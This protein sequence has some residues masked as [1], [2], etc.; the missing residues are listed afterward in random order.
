MDDLADRLKAVDLFAGLEPAD[1][2][3]IASAAAVLELPAG[4]TLVRQGEDAESTFVLLDGRLAAVFEDDSQNERALPDMAPGSLV[5]EV[6][7]FAGGKRTATVR[8]KETSTLAVLSAQAF[9]HL[10][11]ANPAVASRVSEVVS[12]RLRQ[13]QLV[14]HLTNLFPDIEPDALRELGRVVEWISLPTGQILFRQGDVGDAAYLIISGRV[15]VALTDNAEG[16]ER[17]VGEIPSGEMV[18]EQAIL[19]DTKRSATIYAGRDTE[20]ARIPRAV[21]SAFVESHPEIMLRM[22]RT[23][24]ERSR[25]AIRRPRRHAEQRLSITVVALDPDATE[26]E[27]AQPLVEELT[28]FG[29]TIALSSEGIDSALYKPGI[30]ESSPGDPAHI[31]LLQW[32][33]DVERSHRFVIYRTDGRHPRWTERAIRQSDHVIFFAR[34]SG[35]PGLRDVESRTR[36]LRDGRPQRSSLVLRHARDVER[37]IG[38]AR[39]LALRDVESVHHVRAGDAASFARLARI[40]AG[41]AV[42]VVFG[43]GG[44]RGFAHLGVLRA[45][46]ELGVPVDIIGGASIGAAVSAPTAQGMR[47]DD[48]V[49]T[50]TH[51]FRSLL[52]YT[53]PLASL[54]SGRRITDALQRFGGT[55]DLEDLW[56]SYYCV[57]TNITT[58]RTVVHRRGNLARAV[59]ASIAIPGVLPPVPAGDDLLVDGGVL[60]NLPIDVMREINP[61]GPVIAVHVVSRK[62]PHA[63]A[64]FGLSLSGWRVAIGRLMPR[65]RRVDVPSLVT[66]ILRSMVVGAESAVDGML[67]DGLPDLYL[68]INASAVGLLAFETVGKVEKI[69]YEAAIEPLRTWIEGGGLEPA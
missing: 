30:S 12:R 52:D 36:P 69:G 38:T 9:A 41:R 25:A 48:A 47:I 37:P 45:L 14:T 63:K 17:V 49:A 67:N 50:V 58:S 40:L 23:I 2:R 33:H 7:L 15:R 43:G 1:L 22:I 29:P 61:T 8:A 66:T 46:D 24:V 55:W 53:L 42:G 19:L 57:S 20:L 54:L 65:R 34:A 27:L 10:L 51:Y 3:A 13:V 6:A 35:D 26:A 32:L 16:G 28:K 31:R 5:G 39:W 44:A 11:E 60:N 64:D 21:F 68:N 56:L 18:G 62:G 59:R 4:G